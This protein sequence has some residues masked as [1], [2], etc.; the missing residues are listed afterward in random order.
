[1]GVGWGQVKRDC[2]AFSIFRSDKLHESHDHSLILIVN[3]KT[4]LQT[5]YD[6]V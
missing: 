6:I 3:W 4:R 1:M 2:E 5:Q